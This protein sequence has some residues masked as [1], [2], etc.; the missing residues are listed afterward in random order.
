MNDN[1]NEDN[2]IENNE[3]NNLAINTSGRPTKVVQFGHNEENEGEEQ[4]KEIE[5][6]DVKLSPYCNNFFF[7]KFC[8][9]YALDNLRFM[10]SKIWKILSFE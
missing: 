10:C 6:K 1:N 8:K 5:D 3:I 4:I 2:L 9:W 7:I